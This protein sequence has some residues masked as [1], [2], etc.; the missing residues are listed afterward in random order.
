MPLDSRLARAALALLL[1]GAV[2]PLPASAAPA[3]ARGPL[4]GAGPARSVR[5]ATVHG[6]LLVAFKNGSAPAVAATLGRHGVRAAHGAKHV[7]AVNVPTGRT[8]AAML[9]ELRKDANVAYAEPDYERFPLGYVAPNDPD[10]NNATT[11]SRAG[12][13]STAYGK[14]WW[15]RS[16]GLNAAAAWQHGFSDPADRNFPVRAPSAVFKVAVLD[17]GF[18]MTHPDKGPNIVA[19]KDEFDHR[20]SSGNLVTD[21]DV[22]PPSID[23]T[24]G[25]DE[26]TVAHGTCTAGEVAAA[27]DNGA[28]VASVGYDAQ[29]RVYKVMGYDYDPSSPDFG[30]AYIDDLALINGI[31]DAVAD[32]CRV[33]SMSIGGPDDSAAIQAAVNDAWNAGC[34]VAAASGNSGTNGVLYPAGDANV[35]GVGSYGVN[36]HG[37]FRSSFTNFGTGLDVLAP[38]EMVW[39]LASP[40]HLSADGG[41]VPGYEFWDGTSMATPAAAGAIAHLWRYVPALS[42]Q[43]IIDVAERTAAP[44]GS[45]R[46]NT[47][48]GWGYMDMSAAISSI[49]ATYGYLAAP[50][51]HAASVVPTGTYMLSWD[52]VTGHSVVYGVSLDGSHVAT[53]SGTACPLAL[54]DGVHNVSVQAAS[55]YDYWDAAGSA[56]ATF[57]AGAIAG[58]APTDHWG[59]FSPTGWVNTRT[60]R[61]S[62]QARDATSGLVPGQAEFRCSSNAGGTWSGWT[63][64]SLVCPYYS[65]TTQTVE[66]TASFSADSETDDLVQFRVTNASSLV[67]TSPAFAVHVDSTAPTGTLVAA[68]GESTV[69]TI[70]VPITSHVTDAHLADMRLSGDG[71]ATWSAWTTYTADATVTLSPGRGPKTVEGQYRDIAGNVLTCSDSL[72]LSLPV[73]LRRVAGP[74]RYDTAIQASQQFASADTVIVATGKDFADALSASGLAG[75]YRAPI[76]LTTPWTLYKDIPAEIARLH[77]TKAIVVGGEP[78]VSRAVFQQLDALPNV[79][80]QRVAGAD[81][82]GTSAAIVS[83]LLARE[84]S[85][86]RPRSTHAIIARGDSFADALAASPVAYAGRVPVL[87][88]RPTAFPQATWDAFLS[89]QPTPSSGDVF[90]VGGPPAVGSGVTNLLDTYHRRWTRLA[91]GDRYETAAAVALYAADHLGAS[92]GTVGVATGENFPDALGGGVSIGERGGVLL[93]THTGSLSAPCA[94]ALGDHSPLVGA[95]DVFGGESAVSPGVMGS[96]G[97]L[98]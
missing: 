67:G 64:A 56:T 38:G 59:A 61:A 95:V 47:S 66:A 98:F 7:F 69:T 89:V 60:P 48:Y 76:L 54:S 75:S 42:N 23:D 50:T 84:S 4:P 29:V 96:I 58:A 97:A 33:I 65:T 12:G 70:T 81:R 17:T 86:G 87:L 85:L 94:T 74:N 34:V 24:A 8:D 49:T 32:G 22:T 91:G 6:V 31:E 57:L 40:T 21:F 55:A 36:S 62:V 78:A 72:A 5:S 77:A 11:Y 27:T 1:T 45:G 68:S 83:E 63:P 2:V 43:Q 73:A 30:L 92:W 18:Y 13:V 28:G 10:Y 52:A 88:V 79:S 44:A 15:L 71:G 46:P 93:L 19:G 90:V 14:S 51:L 41:G 16:G 9:A 20:D 26:M 35:V 53:V 3:A 25:A 39:G 37:R 82:Y 80:V